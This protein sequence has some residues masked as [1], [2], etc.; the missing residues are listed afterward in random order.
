MEKAAIEKFK[1]KLADMRKKVI[2][3]KGVAVEG[4]SKVFTEEEKVAVTPSKV[5][6]ANA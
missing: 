5:R 3:K 4:L 2:E 6:E 1:N